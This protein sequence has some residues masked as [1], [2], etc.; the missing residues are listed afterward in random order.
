M[1]TVLFVAIVIV[2]LEALAI[3]MG[4]FV[5]FRKCR[6]C[7][8]RKSLL[9]TEDSADSS[10]PQNCSHVM[11]HFKCWGCG[12]EAEREIGRIGQRPDGA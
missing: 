4:E 3:M 2:A 10:Y 6:E 1:Q 5:P 8:S 9:W 11:R 7:G 12:H